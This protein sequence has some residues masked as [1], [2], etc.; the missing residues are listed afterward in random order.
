MLLNKYAKSKGSGKTAQMSYLTKTFAVK[1]HSIQA[2]RTP[3]REILL[4]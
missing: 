4:Q 2:Q 1:P 3:Q